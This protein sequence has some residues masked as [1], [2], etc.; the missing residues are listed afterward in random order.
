MRRRRTLHR[1]VLQ[2]AHQ[3]QP[4]HLRLHQS[5]YSRHR[6]A[7]PQRRES[8]GPPLLRSPLRQAAKE[9]SGRPRERGQAQQR[10]RH[11]RQKPRRESPRPL[12]HPAF[13]Q[14]RQRTRPRK[15]QRDYPPKRQRAHPRGTDPHRTPDRTRQESCPEHEWCPCQIANC[16][17]R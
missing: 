12:P 1:P 6:Q 11:V 7:L 5:L 3:R 9:Q 13:R 4:A 16:Q 14:E 15:R 8:Q 17:Q 2:P 10:H